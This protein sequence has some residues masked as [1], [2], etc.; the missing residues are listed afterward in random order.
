[1]AVVNGNDVGL[2]IGS[3]LIGCL[4]NATFDSG[5][6]TIDVTCKDNGGAKQTLP[7]GNTATINFEGF[8]NPSSTFGISELLPLHQNK[9]LINWHFGDNTNLTMHGSGYIDTLNFAA[10]LNA[11]TTFSGVINVSGPWTFSET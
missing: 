8:F 11:G 5:N 2:S 9:T 6:E 7:G 10:P 1:M 3:Q 4:T